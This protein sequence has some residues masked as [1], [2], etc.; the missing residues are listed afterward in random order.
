MRGISLTCP[1]DFLGASQNPQPRRAGQD[2][3]ESYADEDMYQVIGP[4]TEVEQKIK[5]DLPEG[6]SSFGRSGSRDR[7]KEGYTLCALCAFAVK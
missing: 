5:M 1:G 4:P 3:P 6:Q 2:Y 7:T